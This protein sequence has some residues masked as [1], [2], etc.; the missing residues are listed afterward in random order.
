MMRRKK[1]C[2]PN[3]SI[4]M[5]FIAIGIGVFLANIL[6]Y[7]LLICLFGLA[8]ICAGISFIMKK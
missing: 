4:G 3:R 8:L 6:P 5:I 2:G 7:Y 1:C